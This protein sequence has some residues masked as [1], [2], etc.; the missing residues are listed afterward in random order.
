MTSPVSGLSCSTLNEDCSRLILV[1]TLDPANPIH[2]FDFLRGRV[3][4]D[5]YGYYYY[6]IIAAA[7]VTI[8][9]STE[10][11]QSYYFSI[12]ATN[13]PQH[14][15]VMRLVGGG[16]NILLEFFRGATTIHSIGSTSIPH[17][18]NLLHCL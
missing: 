5:E 13:C 8:R 2:A 11:A 15:Y 4:G 17:W 3:T 9:I 12:L 18:T 10:W 6:S 1:T 16:I 7:Q 14:E